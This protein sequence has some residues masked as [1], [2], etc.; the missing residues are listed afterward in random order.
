M[1]LISKVS[2]EFFKN[3]FCK[4]HKNVIIFFQAVTWFWQR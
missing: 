4:P 3:N 2:P 1:S